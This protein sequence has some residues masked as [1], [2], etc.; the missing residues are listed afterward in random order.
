[1]DFTPIAAVMLAVVVVVKIVVWKVA[2]AEYHRSNNVSLEAL[3]LD[4]YNDILSNASAL[5]FAGLTCIVQDIWWMDPVGGVLISVYIIRSWWLTAT[6]QVNMLVG[7]K[8]SEEFLSS[9]GELAGRVHGAELDL[10]RAYHFGPKCLVEVKLIMEPSTTLKDSRNVSI[11]LQHQI[12]LLEDCERCFVQTDYTRREE[13]DHD[14]KVPLDKK[15]NDADKK[16]RLR[17]FSGDGLKLRTVL[18][19][20]ERTRRRTGSGVAEIHGRKGSFSGDLDPS[21][22]DVRW[23]RLSS[24]G[25]M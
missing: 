23:T 1:M 21:A 14:T 13:D 9:V 3:A 25:T 10:V 12:E 17:S 22:E 8:A 6:E 2:Q 16:G 15:L 4:N 18:S 24:T 20:T 19:I 7:V 11:A 5:L